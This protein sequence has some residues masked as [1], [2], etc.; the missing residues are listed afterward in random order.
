MK[1]DPTFWIEARA[2]GLAAY[3]LLTGSVVAGLVLKARPFGK[4]L[5]PATVTDL[6][7]FL[8]LLAL[9]AT[10]LHGITPVLDQSVS[11]TWVSLL[12]P[13]EIPYRPLWTGIGVV[14]AELMLLV[15]V[16]FPQRKRI[17]AKNW[18]RLHWTTYGVFAALTVHRVM[19]GTDTS[20]P[21]TLGLYLGAIGSVVT[22][23]VIRA[24]VPPAKPERRRRELVTE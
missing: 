21:W 14:A 23:T 12:V 19:S 1:T 4:A 5:K 20:R 16:S 6:H 2:S 15:F 18:R 7:R 8:A 17:G 13:G 9:G 11:I 24:V 22:S 10:A 3:L